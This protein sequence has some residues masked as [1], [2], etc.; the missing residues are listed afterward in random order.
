LNPLLLNDLKTWAI[1][2][3]S[4][5]GGYVGNVVEERYLTEDH[6]DPPF[7]IALDPA[8][9]VAGSH[10]LSIHP[11]TSQLQ[12]AARVMA[13]LPIEF[14]VNETTIRLHPISVLRLGSLSPNDFKQMGEKIL[15]GISQ[16][17]QIRE[18]QRTAQSGLVLAKGMP[19]LP[20]APGMR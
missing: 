16:A 18:Q 5:D 2:Y 20:K 12:G 4:I 15:I 13:V 14:L 6:V 1:A 17:E 19:N 8:Y 9:T 7:T 3:T 10:A 11:Q